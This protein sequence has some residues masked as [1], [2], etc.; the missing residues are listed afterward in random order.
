MFATTIHSEKVGPGTARSG[1]PR[2]AKPE[3]A[4]LDWL[5]HT[6]VVVAEARFQQGEG[7]KPPLF[8]LSNK[9]LL[10][11]LRLE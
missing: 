9:S 11:V 8:K 5:S 1:A 7:Y 4:L 6:P 2:I 10:V 3:A